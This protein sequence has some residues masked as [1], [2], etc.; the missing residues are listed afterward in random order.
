MR[1][2]GRAVHCGCL[3][4]VGTDFNELSRT[5]ADSTKLFICRGILKGLRKQLEIPE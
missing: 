2:E 3:E 4:N 5:V 1:Y